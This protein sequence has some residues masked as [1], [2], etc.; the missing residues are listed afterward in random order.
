[1]AYYKC[2]RLTNYIIIPNIPIII[3]I[4][5]RIVEVMWMWFVVVMLTQIQSGAEGAIQIK[6]NT[7]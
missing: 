2:L 6:Y 3:K 1:M 7:K 5:N 4:T